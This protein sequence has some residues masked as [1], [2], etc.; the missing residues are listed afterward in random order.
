MVSKS[1]RAWVPC[2]EGRTRANWT[3]RR[4]RLFPGSGI[5]FPQ[6]GVFPDR[7]VLLLRRPVFRLSQLTEKRHALGLGFRIRHQQ[8][9][10]KKREVLELPAS[11]DKVML[12][13][14]ICGARNRIRK[15]GPDSKI[16][17]FPD[18]SPRM[19]LLFR[20]PRTTAVLRKDPLKCE[21]GH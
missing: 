1:N 7:G 13:V 14:R 2:G 9:L 4:F 20:P 16:Q 3:F 6:S 17:C 18:G 10:E 12:Q 11:R 5:L 8:W 21:E 19:E 15:F